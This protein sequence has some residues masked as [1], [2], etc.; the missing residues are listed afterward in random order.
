MHECLG[1]PRS[2]TG[3][4][5]LCLCSLCCLFS[6]CLTLTIANNSVARLSNRRRRQLVQALLTADRASACVAVLD[7]AQEA[8]GKIGFLLEAERAIPRFAQLGAVAE[9]VRYVE[10]RAAESSTPTSFYANTLITAFGHV[11]NVEGVEAVYA[12]LRANDVVGWHP[13][14]HTLRS[15]L[16]AL[17]LASPS[18]SISHC[19]K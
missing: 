10:L 13:D 9:G 17:G 6:L 15:M 11:N 16:R 2:S 1:R 18:I 8:G 19:A 4:A 12:K 14:E 7:A 3:R 5:P